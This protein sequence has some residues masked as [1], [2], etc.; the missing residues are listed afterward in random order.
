V[1]SLLDDV[2]LDMV[3]HSPRQGE[4]VEG[5]MVVDAV[6]VEQ[7]LG[8]VTTFFDC[9]ADDVVVVVAVYA[10]VVDKCMYPIEVDGVDNS[11]IVFLDAVEG[12]VDGEN[13]ETMNLHASKNVIVV[14]ELKREHRYL[15]YYLR[16][17][18]GVESTLAIH[19]MM[20]QV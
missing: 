13:V 2:K 4:V 20:V 8:C 6:E 1:C 12:V 14:I 19:L 3:V 11:L 15:Y 5:Q 17:V 7:L 18:C 10:D 9:A 16:W